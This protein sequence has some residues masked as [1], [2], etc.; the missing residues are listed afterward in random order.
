[1][2][3]LIAID[4]PQTLLYMFCYEGNLHKIVNIL[5]DNYVNV[6][7]N[8]IT[9]CVTAASTYVSAGSYDVLT[10]LI[11]YAVYNHLPLNINIRMFSN[12]CRFN[13]VVLSKKLISAYPSQI[14]IYHI[15]EVLLRMRKINRNDTNWLLAHIPIP[16]IIMFVIEDMPE[17]DTMLNFQNKDARQVAVH[18]IRANLKC[19]YQYL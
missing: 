16:Y 10:Y 4:T 7:A 11:E 14:T 8:V 9:N 12:I 3:T 6:D 5:T 17:Y 19:Q 1:M 18:R 15:M 13:R 2:D